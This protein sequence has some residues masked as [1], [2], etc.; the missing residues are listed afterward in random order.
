MLIGAATGAA[1]SAITGGDIL[2]GAMFGAL[3]GA[4]TGGMGG[5][6]E[7]TFLTSLGGG[8]GIMATDLAVSASFGTITAGS[9]LAFGGTSLVGSIGMGMLFP[10]P[11]AGYEQE[12][13]GY[14][15][16]AYNSMHNQVTGSGG[17]QAPAVL[18]S[19]IKRAKS[20][21]E[22]QQSTGDSYVN[23]ESF[24]NTG[25]QLA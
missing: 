6:G 5:F 7:G 16:I 12:A 13:Y 8:S 15:P 2:Q 19:E 25:L 4:V 17:V 24:A 21:R 23:T 20:K 22:R 3:T 18:A 10:E 11:Q 14:S 1:G 9:A